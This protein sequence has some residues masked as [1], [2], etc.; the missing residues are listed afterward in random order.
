MAEDDLIHQPGWPAGVNNQARDQALPRDENGTP[1]AARAIVNMDMVEGK[2]KTRQGYRRLEEG[3]WHS[4]GVLEGV[5]AAAVRAGDM[6]RFD[7]TGELATIRA[8]VGD[9]LRFVNGKAG[10]GFENTGE[11]EAPAKETLL[12]K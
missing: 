6:V 7:R 8:G 9:R 2:P 12:E 3:R 1:L 10:A 4:P 11:H 5:G